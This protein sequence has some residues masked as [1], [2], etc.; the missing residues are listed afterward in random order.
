MDFDDD[1]EKWA[2]TKNRAS[3]YEQWQKKKKQEQP[4]Y[5]PEAP[6][7]VDKFTEGSPVVEHILNL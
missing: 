4:G 5:Q 7:F 6:T 3:I 2:Q 1:F